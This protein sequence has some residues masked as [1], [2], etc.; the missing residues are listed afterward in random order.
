VRVARQSGPRN[1]SESPSGG[2]SRREFLTSGAAAIGSL[3]GQHLPAQRRGEAGHSD[4]VLHIIG[5]SHIDAAWM[6]PWKDSSNLALTTARSA[7]DRMEETPGFRYSHSSAIHYR[8]IQKADPTMFQ[9]I[10]R[11][12]RE[13]RWEVVGGWPVEPDCNLPSTE[14][15]FRHSLYGKAYCQ[16]ALNADVK[17]GFNPDAFGHAAGLPTILKQSGYEYYVFT[18]PDK[19]V[20][21]LPLLFWW[22][23]PDGSRLLT[24][25]ILHSYTNHASR[26]PEVAKISFAPGMKHGAFFLGVGDHGGAVTIADI[27]E[28]L[29]LRND[30]RLPELRWSTLSEFFHA[31]EQSPGLADLPVI[32]GGLQHAL[33]GCY[34]ACGEQKFQN[35]RSERALVEAESIAALAG[36][37]DGHKYP[38]QEFEDAWWQVLFN[39]FHDILAGTALYS[40]YQDARDGI[41]SACQTATSI[42]VQ[43]LEILAKKVDTSQAEAG[44]IFVFNPLPWQRSALLEYVPN[45]YGPN[46]VQVPITHLKT[47]AGDKVPVQVRPSEGMSNLYPR[48]SAWIELPPL[49]YKILSEEYGPPPPPPSL[50]SFCEISENSF[51]LSSLKAADGMELLASSL[52][53][54]VIADSSDTWG[55]GA[56]QFREEMGRPSFV[57]STLVEDGPVMRIV[58]QT[59]RWRQSDIAVDITTYPA[60][61]CVKLRFTIDW[62]EHQQILKLEV[63]TAL[64]NPNAFAMVPGAIVNKVPDGGEEPYQDWVAL[65]GRIDNREYTVG[66]LNNSTYSF[67]C[68]NGLLRTILIRSAPYAWMYDPHQSNQKSEMP[69]NNIGAWQDQGRQERTFWL[70][71]RQGQCL[72][73]HFDRLSNELETPTEYVMDSRHHGTEAWE[74][75]FLEIAPDWVSILAVK[76]AEGGTD[77]IVLRI[78]ERAGIQTRAVLKSSQFQLDQHISLGPWEI[79]T[80]RIGGL[81]S[82]RLE[83]TTISSLEIE[84]GYK[85]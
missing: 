82:K 67:D 10:L 20:V 57:S 53:L 8:W 36:L 49:G 17:V 45:K 1:N 5:Y 78:Q 50:N 32:K 13:G 58:R 23:G 77:A 85:Q 2:P 75:S 42:K 41:G 29:R 54:V 6:W 40:D 44:V 30:G 73:Q 60:K 37:S 38:K 74:K 25:R 84:A 31:I 52:G 34:S 3:V 9:E 76:Q 55:E 59:L 11:R 12:I 83:V 79:K 27:N 19:D 65:Q 70:V 68:L 24:L 64:I 81:R 51:G 46:M 56:D 22:E 69:A 61:D 43:F 72:D 33:R 39:Q 21:D 7:L 47:S 71:G 80:L 15:F 48:L 35:R 18:R 26:I 4:K 63:P 14:S 62:N 66:L 16:Q 28:V